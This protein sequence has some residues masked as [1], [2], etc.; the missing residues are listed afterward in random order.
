MVRAQMFR[1]VTI[2]G[3]NA[4]SGLR[5]NAT[6]LALPQ[7]LDRR[8]VLLRHVQDVQPGVMQDFVELA[9]PHVS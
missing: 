9:P 3:F 1:S 7:E 5:Q 8:R 4:V 6:S 2:I